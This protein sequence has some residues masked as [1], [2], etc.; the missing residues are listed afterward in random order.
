MKLNE[1]II[2]ILLPIT[3]FAEEFHVDKEADNEVRFTSK[4]QIHEFDGI[5]SEI[6]GY[7]LLKDDGTNE[8]YFEI[9]LETFDTGIGLRNRHMRENYLE[10]EKYPYGIYNGNISEYEEIGDTLHVKT[11]GAMTVHGIENKMAAS[12]K[13]IKTLKGYQGLS[14][15]TINL[16]D[17]KIK[18]PSVMV[19]KLNE[20]IDI[21]VRIFF[22]EVK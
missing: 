13:M 16:K 17:Y 19:M 12:V 5:T 1:I 18:V 22:K 6:D 8:F 2:L 11:I 14:S 20:N 9:P 7:V 15:F 21:K 10:T 3:I 4:T